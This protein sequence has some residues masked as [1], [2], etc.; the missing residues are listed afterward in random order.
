MTIIS[1][2]NMWRH[3]AFSM[4]MF[5]AALKNMPAEVLEAAD[6]EGASGWQR[7]T[8]VTLPILRPT[9]VINL[10]LVTISNLSIFTLIYVMTQGGPGTDTTTLAIYV[11]LQAFSYDQLGYG[12]AVALLLVGIGAVFSVLF[13]RNAEIAP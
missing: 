5:S 6:V 10:L 8:M 3:V 1:V 2:A 11:Y 4:L 7:L 12:T 9:I 13:V